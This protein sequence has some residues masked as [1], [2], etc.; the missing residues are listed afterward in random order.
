M[1][2]QIELALKRLC[3][4]LWKLIMDVAK[5]IEKEA[6]SGLYCIIIY[7]PLHS[8]CLRISKLIRE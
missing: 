8:L 1:K 7:E 5:A 3:L 2:D 4:A 6:D